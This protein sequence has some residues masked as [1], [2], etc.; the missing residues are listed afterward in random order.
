MSGTS[1]I[2][3][4]PKG[5]MP[6]RVSAPI[7]RR[8]SNERDPTRRNRHSGFGAA[9]NAAKTRHAGPDLFLSSLRDDGVH[10]DGLGL[11][12]PAAA[13]VLR[14]LH[15]ARRSEMARETE[16]LRAQQS[17]IADPHR[18]LAQSAEQGRGRLVLY[19]GAGKS[20]PESD[21]SG[22]RYFHLLA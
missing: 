21:A 17:G 8:M 14:L 2:R 11:S 20:R 18:A 4:C 7:C 6:S 3:S 22:G 9:R 16:L 19:I 13:M 5:A 1:S 12:D 15:S 10:R